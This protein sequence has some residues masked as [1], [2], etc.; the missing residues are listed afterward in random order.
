[1]RHTNIFNSKDNSK[2]ESIN[3]LEGY[4]YGEDGFKKMTEKQSEESNVFKDVN[5]LSELSKQDNL[6]FKVTRKIGKEE[7]DE[8][9]K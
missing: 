5:N 7:S 8:I 3:K 6:L 2:E 9:L 1:M 4:T